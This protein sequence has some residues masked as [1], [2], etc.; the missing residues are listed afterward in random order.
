MK[1]VFK[2]VGCISVFA[3]AFSSCTKD[4]TVTPQ[5]ESATFDGTWNVDEKSKEFGPSKY[6]ATIS[7]T[8]TGTVSINYLYGMRKGTIASV[9]GKNLTIQSQT[10]D[11]LTISGTAV[12]ENA[13]RITFNYYVVSSAKK[14]DTVSSVF[15]R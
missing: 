15:T 3:L 12:M 9:N 11:A 8:T 14:T 10:I 2:I 1:N 6:V 7:Y 5:D 13:D 4:D